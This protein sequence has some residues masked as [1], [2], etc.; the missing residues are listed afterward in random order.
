MPNPSIGIETGEHHRT[1][2]HAPD[3]AFAIEFYCQGLCGKFVIGDVWD[4]LTRVDVHAVSTNNLWLIG[5]QP[6][7]LP[8]AL[9]GPSHTAGNGGVFHFPEN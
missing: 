8:I 5:F 1:D 6:V 4:Y 9:G 3:S 2:L 7:F